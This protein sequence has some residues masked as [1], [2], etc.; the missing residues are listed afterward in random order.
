ML[1]ALF[2]FIFEMVLSAIGT[3]IATL[4]GV[5]DAAEVGGVIVGLGIL[6]IGIAIS[7]WGH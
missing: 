1:D 3:V 7:V 4:F 5:D 6:A 2:G